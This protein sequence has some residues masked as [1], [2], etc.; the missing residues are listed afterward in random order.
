ME[1]QSW[2]NPLIFKN[3]EHNNLIKKSLKL[4]EGKLL[5]KTLKLIKNRFKKRRKRNSFLVRNLKC[6][7]KT[8]LKSLKLK[9]YVINSQYEILKVQHC[10][11]RGHLCGQIIQGNIQVPDEAECRKAIEVDQQKEAAF[12]TFYD[13]ID[14]QSEYV[15]HLAEI[16]GQ[17]KVN[18]SDMFKK[19]EMDRLRDITTYKDQSHFE[20]IYGY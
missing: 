16:T 15:D 1:N 2:N 14:F 11:F 8:L 13:E 6:E 18:I 12:K 5:C 7:F 4:W 10:L 3:S 19:W 9:N 20:T 17:R